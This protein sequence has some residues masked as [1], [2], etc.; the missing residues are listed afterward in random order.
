MLG[1]VERIRVQN[2]PLDGAAISPAGI[3]TV[4]KHHF[5]HAAHIVIAAQQA[6][7]LM[8]QG[9]GKWR[10]SVDAFEVTPLFDQHGAEESF[11]SEAAAVVE[12]KRL[13]DITRTG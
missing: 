5:G 2:R 13:E 1:E 8:V 10:D 7:Q 11:A 12:A 9:I 3:R 6:S 4:A